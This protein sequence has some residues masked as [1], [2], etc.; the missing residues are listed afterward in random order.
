MDSTVYFENPSARNSDSVSEIVFLPHWSGGNWDKLLEQTQTQ[1][2]VP[3][4]IVIHAG[5]EDRALYIVAF[6]RFMVLSNRKKRFALNPN[7]RKCIRISTI[8][9]GSVINELAF[10]DGKPSP[11][12]IQAVTECQLFYLN[13][14]AF[15]LFSAQYPQLGQAVLL[16]L[17]RLL[18]LR[19]RRMANLLAYHGA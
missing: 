8:E 13:M 19:I 7:K 11:E 17:G 15:A 3:G 4:D 2:Y 16:D 12:T 10:M 1:F 5:S 6:G 14:D 18:A 9:G